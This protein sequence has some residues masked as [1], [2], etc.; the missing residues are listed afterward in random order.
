MINVYVVI[1]VRFEVLTA[2]TIKKA[3]FWDVRPCGSCKK[4]LTRATRGNIPEDGLHL[5]N[6]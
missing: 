2:V 3:V 5:C 4:L 6:L 1:L